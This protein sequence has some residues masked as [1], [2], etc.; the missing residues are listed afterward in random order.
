M[1]VCFSE[2]FLVFFFVWLGIREDIVGGSEN[3]HRGEQVNPAQTQG[4][5]NDNFED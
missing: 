1:K 5:L 3:S 2:S 4:I